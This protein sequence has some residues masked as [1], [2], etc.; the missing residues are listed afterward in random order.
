MLR[1][2]TGVRFLREPVTEKGMATR[3]RLLDAAERVFGK[4]GYHDAS[5][6]EITRE[7][8]VGLGTF[9]EYFDSKE[10]IFQELVRY[11]SHELRRRIAERVAAYPS[12]AEKERVGFQTFFEFVLEHRDLYWIV[13]Q[14]QFVDEETYKWYY[15]RLAE[16]Y[17][18][19]LQ[20]AQ[21]NG[22]VTVQDL[23]TLAYALLGMG[24]MLGMRWVLWENRLP[25]DEVIETLG[26][27]VMAM[28]H[29]GSSPG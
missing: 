29:A 9:Y 17:L 20:E 26:K 6:A 1:H 10:S 22:E 25:P 13:L 2:K 18:R 23:D 16:G 21:A 5:I 7:A 27:L 24:S 11:M 4:D 15:R 12:R 19:G 3:Q 28:L 14:S 8:G